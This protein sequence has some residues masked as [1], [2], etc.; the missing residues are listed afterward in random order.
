MTHAHNEQSPHTTATSTAPGSSAASASVNGVPPELLQ[1]VTTRATVAIVT[2]VFALLVVLLYTAQL[3]RELQT[4]KRMQTQAIDEKR[5]ENR[6]AMRALGVE[7]NLD[8]QSHDIS[9]LVKIIQEKY[10]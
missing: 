1:A 9:D 4:E 7:D 6:L 2:A 8:L 10:K 5:L 3:H